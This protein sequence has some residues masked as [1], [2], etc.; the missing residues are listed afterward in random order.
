M[1]ILRQP[2]G[3]LGLWALALTAQQP[4]DIVTKRCLPCHNNQLDNAGLSF[5]NQTAVLARSA[6]IRAAI[7]HKGD[8][9]M[10]PGPKLSDREIS[11]LTAWIQEGAPG[12]H[13]T[14]ESAHQ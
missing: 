12:L 3:C 13:A 1:Y 9:K 14:G 2:L 7:T 6:K 11:V 8:V 10:P 5:E 4:I